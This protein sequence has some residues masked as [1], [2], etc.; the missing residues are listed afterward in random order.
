MS[1]GATE[2]GEALKPQIEAVPDQAAFMKWA[3]LYEVGGRYWEFLASGYYIGDKRLAAEDLAIRISEGDEL[4]M[5]HY[6]TVLTK[7]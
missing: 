1:A 5:K 3:I 4:L 7:A 6:T 2:R